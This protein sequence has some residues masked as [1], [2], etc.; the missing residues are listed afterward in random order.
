MKLAKDSTTLCHCQKK[1]FR[2]IFR[3]SQFLQLLGLSSSISNDVKRDQN[4]EAATEGFEV[5]AEAK[6]K[7]MNKKYEMVIDNIT[8]EFISL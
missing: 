4:L 1:Y 3:T 2:I 7:V 8:G 6:Y 5:R